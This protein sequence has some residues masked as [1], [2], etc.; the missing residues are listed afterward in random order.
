MRPG[1]SHARSASRRIAPRAGPRS[2]GCRTRSSSY[3]RPCEGTTARRSGPEKA[4]RR[5]EPGRREPGGRCPHRGNAGRGAT[6]PAPDL[7]PDLARETPASPNG[8]ETP[9]LRSRVLRLEA[10]E[11]DDVASRER[12]TRDDRAVVPRGQAV[13]SRRRTE[14]RREFAVNDPGREGTSIPDELRFSR[15]GR[16]RPAGCARGSS[17]AAPR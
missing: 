11:R 6:S 14:H 4:H 13:R 8:A 1:R 9:A 17:C 5:I 12:R 2:N 15:R 16:D 10:R 3:P 7:A